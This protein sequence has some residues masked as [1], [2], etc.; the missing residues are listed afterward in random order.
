ML[1]MNDCLSEKYG[2]SV[3]SENEY[4][5]LVFIRP[6]ILDTIPLMITTY[7]GVK[8]FRKEGKN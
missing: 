1:E 4:I 7:L 2:T 3:C 6:I 8:M 5:Y